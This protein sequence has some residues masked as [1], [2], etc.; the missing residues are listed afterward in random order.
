MV[1]FALISLALIV[2]LAWLLTLVFESPEAHRAI[3]I[4]AIVA[5]LVQLFAFA[6]A[7]GMAKDNIIAGWGIGV[8]MRLVTLA[9]YA[10]VL[11]RAFGVPQAPALLSL[12]AFLFVSTIVEPVLLKR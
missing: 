3:R 10:L 6:V 5:Y 7:K 12:A 11:V 9:L 2:G 1:L 4:S 8:M